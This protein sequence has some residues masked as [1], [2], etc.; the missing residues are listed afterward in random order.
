MG[1]EINASNALEGVEMNY[2]LVAC[3]TGLLIL[4]GCTSVKYNGGDIRTHSINEPAPGQVVTRSI[5][6]QMLPKGVVVEE[7]VLSVRQPI[8]GAL[9]AIP[10]GDYVQVGSDER[11]YFYSP[12][13]VTK[14]AIADP[15]TALAVGRTPGAELCAVAVFGTSNCYKGDF[16]RKKRTR[17]GATG[18]HQTLLY[19]G[20]VDNKINIGYREFSNDMA[21]PAFNNDVEYDLSASTLIGYKGASIEIISADNSSITYRVLRSFSGQ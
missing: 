7:F 21:R 19:N 2:K 4:T 5:G 1:K 20:R 17:P 6:D 18:F 11:N 16:L 10:A 12:I 13:G 15:I 9:Y 14:S 3:I 8:Q